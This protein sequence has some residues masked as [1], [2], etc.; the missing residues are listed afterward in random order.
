MRNKKAK[1]K[2]EVVNHLARKSKIFSPPYLKSSIGG[3][4][5]G[6]SSLTTQGGFH[7]KEQECFSNWSSG[8]NLIRNSFDNFA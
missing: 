1:A 6:G 7:E 8:F 4:F 3:D 2:K 5:R